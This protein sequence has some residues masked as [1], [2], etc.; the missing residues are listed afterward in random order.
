MNSHLLSLFP[1]HTHHII[2]VSD[3]DNLLSGEKSLFELT[4]RGFL[5]IKERDPV[6]L[7]RRVEEVKPI[8][9]DNPIIIVSEGPLTDFPYDLYQQAHLVKL[10]LHQFFPKLSYPVIQL[11][12]AEQI[13]KLAEST[14]PQNTLSRQ[15][16]IEYLL[17]EVFSFDL[18]SLCKPGTLISWLSDFHKSHSPIPDLFRDEIVKKL[19]SCSEYHNWNINLL[20]QDREASFNFVQQNWEYAVHRNIEGHQAKES[21]PGYHLDFQ[22]NSLLQDLVPGLIRKGTLQPVQV[23][24][25]QRFPDWVKPGITIFDDRLQRFSNLQKELEQTLKEVRSEGLN[26]SG[27][28]TWVDMANLWAEA[29][30]ISNEKDIILNE[31]QLEQHQWIYAELDKTFASWIKSN[32]SSL[33]VQRLPTPH[34]VYHIPHYLSYLVENKKIKKLVLMV[35]D[36]MSLGD[37]LQ[38]QPIWKQRNATWLLS[39]SCLLAQIPTIT[40]ISRYALISGLRPT[41]FLNNFEP[42]LP[43]HK[44]WQ[45]FWSKYGFSEQASNLMLLSLDRSS[46]QLADL[47]NPA[48]KVWCL[49]DDTIDKLSHNAVL[50]AVDQQASLGLWLDPKHEE[51]SLMI[52]KVINGFLEKGYEV[53]ICSDHGHVESTGFGQPSEGLMAQTR[54][55][56]ARIYKDR[57]A[58]ERVQ[59]GFSESLLWS[60]DGLLPHEMTVLMPFRKN[61]FT[62]AGERVVTHG[63]ASIEEMIVPFIQINKVRD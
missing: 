40:S 33:G 63:G 59:Q 12:S 7:R 4:Q 21:D 27:W 34:H 15:K 29:T 23:R 53:F 54:G 35:L 5:I 52:E 36:G 6:L 43:Q 19:S 50:G 47:N 41:E 48:V 30:L 61:A 51:N 8:T 31:K 1:I 10:S 20:I 45:V 11:L 56:R 13:E 46:D 58:A 17:Q 2:L 25:E 16:T 18:S 42:L 37:W 49:I 55:K 3:P 24:E 26:K 22:D 28:K 39:T 38:I 9:A 14:S 32:Y 57:L 44:A 62:F 60:D